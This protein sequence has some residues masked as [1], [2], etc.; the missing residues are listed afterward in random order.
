MKKGE[1]VLWGVVALI[2]VIA[3]GNFAVLEW[4]GFTTKKPIYTVRTHFNFSEEGLRGFR[5]YRQSDCYSC[6]RAIGSGTNMG[7]TLDGIG[8]KRNFDY[9]YNFLKEPEKTY[10][11]KTVQHGASPKEADYVSAIPDAD[12]RAMAVFMSELKS[13]QGSSSAFQP[14]KGESSFIDAM[15]DMWVPEGWRNQFRDVREVQKLKEQAKEQAKEQVPEQ[16]KEQVQEQVQE[17]EGQLR[18]GER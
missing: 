7:L 5:V 2:V 16:A 18:D 8:S 3:L 12:L 1:K 15:L 6:H 14:P 10:R 17:Q 4:I 13:D 11:A 9:L